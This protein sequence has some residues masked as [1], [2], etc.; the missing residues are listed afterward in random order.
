M[1]ASQWEKIISRAWFRSTDLWV[2]GPARF[3]CAT[4][5]CVAS[6]EVNQDSIALKSE[7]VCPCG[8]VFDN[9]CTR[10]LPPSSRVFPG[11]NS[12]GTTTTTKTLKIDL[13]PLMFY[14]WAKINLTQDIKYLR[15]V[16][17]KGHNDGQIHSY[18]FETRFTSLQEHEHLIHGETHSL[19]NN[20]IIFAKQNKKNTEQ[21]ENAI[22][23]LHILHISQNSV[24]RILIRD[25]LFDEK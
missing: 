20:L 10:K 19:S 5:L 22:K 18:A 8:G 9:R 3:Q 4:L 17:Q 12:P 15:N 7:C 1:A 24:N 11:V 6:W 25:N 13:L 16:K 14:L 23:R 2:M 21:K